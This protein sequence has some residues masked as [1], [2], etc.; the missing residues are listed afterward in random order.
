M[1]GIGKTIDADKI[2]LLRAGVASSRALSHSL[3]FRWSPVAVRFIE[4]YDPSL[5]LSQRRLAQGRDQVRTSTGLI[6]LLF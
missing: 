1:A 5:P 2:P 4:D 6:S 3:I